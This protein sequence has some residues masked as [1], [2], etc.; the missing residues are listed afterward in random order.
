MSNKCGVR[1]SCLLQGL[2]TCFGALAGDDAVRFSSIPDWPMEFGLPAE[3]AKFQ[4]FLAGKSRKGNPADFP[5]V[6]FTNESCSA[7]LVGPKVLLT[8]AHCMNADAKVVLTISGSDVTGACTVDPEYADKLDVTADW[9]LCELAVDTPGIPFESIVPGN[10]VTKGV[11]QILLTGFGCTNVVRPTSGLGTFRIG[12]S[13][14]DR[15]PTSVSN[16]LIA[17][18]GAVLCFGDSGGPSYLVEPGEPRRRWQVATSGRIHSSGSESYLAS[19]QTS[20]ARRFMANWTEARALAICGFNL[21][22]DACAPGPQSGY[23]TT[24]P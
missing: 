6:F 4:W 7:S 22:T 11:T 12:E 2:L 23:E 1:V 3:K 19:L 13:H 8:A 15:W 17:S 16:F 18:G 14:V 20:S 5:A 10:L 21:A 24:A 9:A